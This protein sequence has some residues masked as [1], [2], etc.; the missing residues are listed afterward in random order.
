M[1]GP[2]LSLLKAKASN[3]LSF[4]IFAVACQDRRSTL[5]PVFHCESL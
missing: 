1:A 5:N 4:N 2:V 3:E